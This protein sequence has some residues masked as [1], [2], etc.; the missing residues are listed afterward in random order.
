M[1]WDFPYKGCTMRSRTAWT[2]FGLLLCVM[3]AGAAELKLATLF[4]DHM[5]LQRNKPVKIWGWADGKGPPGS[6]S[7]KSGTGCCSR[8]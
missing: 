3:S 8:G 2:A 1:N 7:R 6:S 4:Q 5:V